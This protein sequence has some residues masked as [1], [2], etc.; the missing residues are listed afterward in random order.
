MAPKVRAYRAGLEQRD[1]AARALAW[2]LPSVG[3]QG[4]LTKLAET[5]LCAQLAFQ[6]RVRAYHRRLRE[7]YYGY[8]FRDRPF[9]KPDFNRAPRFDG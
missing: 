7:F 5:D 9:G 1:A 8:L 3:V 4:L 2:V 6:D